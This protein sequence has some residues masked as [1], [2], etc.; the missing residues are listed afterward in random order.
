MPAL[1]DAAAA[2]YGAGWELRRRLYARGV[3]TPTR[4]RARVV[5]V[6]NMTVGGA[7]KTT[8]TL[9]L[10]RGLLRRGVDAAVVCRRYRGIADASVLNLCV[11]GAAAVAQLPGWRVTLGYE[12]PTC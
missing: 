3:L 11:S 7:G 9:H 2:V 8:L 6:G 1:L 5:S 10:A 12:D 4:V